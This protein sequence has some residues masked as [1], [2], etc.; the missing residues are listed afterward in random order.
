MWWWIFRPGCRGGSHQSLAVEECG[1]TVARRGPLGEAD[2]VVELPAQRVDF[3]LLLFQTQ[4]VIFR[5]SLA[6][7]HP[8]IHLNGSPSAR[9]FQ[10]NLQLVGKDFS[11]PVDLHNQVANG[12][13]YFVGDRLSVFFNLMQSAKHNVNKICS[14]VTH[15]RQTP[16]NFYPLLMQLETSSMAFLFS[17]SC[18]VMFSRYCLWFL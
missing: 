4:L 1:A 18:C 9:G 7:R 11:L 3:I 13:L 15:K 17:C 8:V 16:M 6:K 5:Q 2:H 14:E 10:T 12:L